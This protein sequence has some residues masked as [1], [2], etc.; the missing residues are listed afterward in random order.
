[1]SRTLPR[2]RCARARRPDGARAVRRPA[3]GGYAPSGISRPLSSVSWFDRCKPGSTKFT[4]TMCAWASHET[5]TA[6]AAAGHRRDGVHPM[7]LV[8]LQRLGDVVS[9]RPNARAIVSTACVQ[10][11]LR[12][13]PA[14]ACRH[15]RSCLD[16]FSGAASGMGRTRASGVAS[17][18]SRLLT[19]GLCVRGQHRLVGAWRST[20]CCHPGS[21]VPVTK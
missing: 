10:H 7:W 1:M 5:R 6:L 17:V 12:C 11:A 4:L 16:R 13:G 2:W 15:Q 19:L 3:R 20:C 21:G 8:D 14:R 18:R 9:P